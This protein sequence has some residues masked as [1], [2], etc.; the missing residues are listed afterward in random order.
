MSWLDW[1]SGPAGWIG[2]ALVL[3]LLLGDPRWLPHPVVGMGRLIARLERHWNRGTDRAKRLRGAA[4][5][6][7]TV[8]SAFAIAYAVT[9]AA[10]RL[11]P[12]AGWVAHVALIWT[13]VAARGLHEAASAVAVPL[14]HGDL[15][16]AREKLGWIVGRDTE[17]LEEPE[18]VRGT[19]ETVAENTS[20]GVIAPLFWAA[21]GGAPLAMAYRA[22][23]T[24]DSMVGYRNE[25]YRA[26]GWASARLDDLANLI[27][28]RLTALLIWVS[29]PLVS[30]TKPMQGFRAAWRDARKHPSPN[31]GWP[32]AMV[33]GLLSAQLGGLNYYGG[34]ASER[35][36]MGDAIRPLTQSDIGRTVRL[37]YGA[38]FA[39]WIAVAC[40]GWLWINR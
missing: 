22:V 1:A 36:R 3:D 15:K 8:G 5:A 14:A 30:G 7:V 16:R 19:V 32:E 10:E 35:A 20:D 23:N 28:A 33:A 34:V 17:S 29:S 18:I 40:L 4:L 2:A 24:L 12:I 38:A 9:E 31:S 26:F 6:L 13:T 25:R 27:P 39:Y 21:I 11:H 37:M